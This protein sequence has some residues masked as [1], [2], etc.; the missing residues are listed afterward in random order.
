MSNSFVTRPHTYLVACSFE[1]NGVADL[2]ISFTV[3]SIY[4]GIDDYVPLH[5][6]LAPISSNSNQILEQMLRGEKIPKSDW[7]ISAGAGNDS[8]RDF[9]VH[10]VVLANSS[11]ILRAA[12]EKHMSIGGDVLTMVSHEN[13]IVL[14][15]LQSKDMKVL[16]TFIYQKR[17]ALP[18][19]DSVSRVGSILAHIFR[20]E[21]PEFFENWQAELVKKAMA[22]DRNL[23]AETIAECVKMLIFVHSA[24]Q[25]ALLA[26]YNCALIVAA[27]SLQIA[28]KSRNC[29]KILKKV[30][31][32]IGLE[33]PIIE[34][35]LEIIQDFKETVCGVEK[36]QLVE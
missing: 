5:P 28:E 2:Q 4:F 11:Y 8:P 10:G 7:V 23:G 24:P 6:K 18:D 26:A 25:G 19:F 29:E 31:K 12:I 34:N 20:E 32:L 35:I 9:H 3:D 1:T 17:F 13:R 36:L 16:L 14:P 30:K 21:I 15:K 27:D 33:W 22:L